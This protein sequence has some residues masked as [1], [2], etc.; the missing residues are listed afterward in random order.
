VIE[1]IHTSPHRKHVCDEN[2]DTI[3]GAA[4]AGEG[5]VQSLAKCPGYNNNKLKKDV[6]HLISN[7]F[8][9]RKHGDSSAFVHALEI[10]PG[11]RNKFSFK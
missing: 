10:C 11:Y 7:T 2:G 9:H 1:L 8:P 5:L 4:A 3:V 6:T